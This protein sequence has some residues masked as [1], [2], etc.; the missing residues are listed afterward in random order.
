MNYDWMNIFAKIE[1]KDGSLYSIHG[2]FDKDADLI[3]MYVTKGVF[4]LG[5]GMS[6]N[7]LKEQYGYV[8]IVTEI[9]RDDAFLEMI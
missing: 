7:I 8:Y 1:H 3:T 4:N 9:S 6:F 2:A 5:T